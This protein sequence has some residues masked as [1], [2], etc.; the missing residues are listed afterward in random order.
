M[1]LSICTNARNSSFYQNF[2]LG[3][4]GLN[5]KNVSIVLLFAG[6]KIINGAHKVE[7]IF[8]EN[9]CL[10]SPQVSFTAGEL[11]G[12]LCYHIK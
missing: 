2:T 5:R 12:E 3:A 11:I 10:N 6:Q 1:T 7:L 9:N 4:L 8:R